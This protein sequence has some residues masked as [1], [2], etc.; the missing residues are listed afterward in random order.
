ML[1]IY[2][3]F[4]NYMLKLVKYRVCFPYIQLFLNSNKQ[5]TLCH[6][7]GLDGW[8][9]NSAFRLIRLISKIQR[10]Q[11]AQKWLNNSKNGFIHCRCLHWGGLVQLGRDAGFQWIIWCEIA[12]IWMKTKLRYPLCSDFQLLHYFDVALVDWYSGVEP[13]SSVL[14]PTSNGELISFPV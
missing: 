8:W 6:Y 13:C 12:S 11:R 2:Q 3:V 9:K 5:N 1:I 4:L 7:R 14:E 10:E